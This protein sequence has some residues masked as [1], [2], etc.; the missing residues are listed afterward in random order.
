MSTDIEPIGL[1]LSPQ[2]EALIT[3]LKY[4]EE[5]RRK[6]YDELFCITP[7]KLGKPA[8]RPIIQSPDKQEP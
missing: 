2:V 1:S 8:P 6:R 4:C 5:Q 7:D 3:Y